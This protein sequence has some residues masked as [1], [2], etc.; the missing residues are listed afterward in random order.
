MGRDSFTREIKSLHKTLGKTNY[1]ETRQLFLNN[2]L[3]EALDDGTPKY[4]N[5]NILGRYMRKD[6]GNFETNTTKNS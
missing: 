1:E 4:Y 6:Y 3:M 5:S 2:V